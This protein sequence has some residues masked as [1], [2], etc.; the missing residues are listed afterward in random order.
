M[1]AA[2]TISIYCKDTSNAVQVP[3]SML[4]YNITD[5]PPWF[6]SIL[7]GMQHF[8]LLFGG[9]VSLPLLLAP[10]LCISPKDSGVPFLISSIFFVA[11]LDTLL[12]LTLGVRLPIIQGS[13]FTFFGPA[14]A[15][16]QLPRWQCPS[17]SAI[18][19]MNYED[20]QEL[21]FSR[22]REIQGAI[23]LSSLV[24]VLLGFTGAVGFLVRFIGP[25]TVVPTIALTGLSLFGVAAPWA[26]RHWGITIFAI[27][28][29]TFFS[30]Y[31]PRI[32]WRCVSVAWEER[33]RTA[34]QLFPVLMTVVIAWSLCAILTAAGALPDDPKAYGYSARTDIKLDTLSQTPWFRFPYPFQWGWPTFSLSGLSMISGVLAGIV[35]S[36]GDYYACARIAGAPPPPTHA[37]NRGI[38]MEGL[39]CVLAGI[40][41]TGSG[42]TSYSEN[43][44]ALGITKV[45]SRRVV[46][47]AAVVMMGIG[48]FTKFAGLLATMPDP[49]VGGLYCGLF[50]M[51]SAVGLS[52]LQS[53][54]LNSTRNL[55]VLGFSLFMGLTVPH[56]VS[57]HKKTLDTMTSVSQLNQVV[58]V[59]LTTSM[60][61]GG[62][63][64]CLLDN[65]LPGTPQERG[66]TAMHSSVS[67]EDGHLIRE[68]Y[69]P[70][71]FL[72][73]LFNRC[74]CT[75]YLPFWPKPHKEEEPID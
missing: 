10:H 13:T 42:T 38:G 9:T 71:G 47:C 41:G 31:A 61:V 67:T 52:Q 16:L 60:F 48:I 26:G 54:D 21:W 59:L 66:L 15:I 17:E 14:I 8:L 11:G 69:H 7:L 70:P 72:I 35:E 29:L 18:E 62:F 68:I 56:W 36:I 43:I 27:A 75:S 25:L 73:R 20:R 50:G 63:L 30:Q 24:E 58:Q 33:I 44:A 65:I 12:Q 32:R 22:V 34:C 55:F 5:E 64:A 19:S 6:L 1:P 4:L 37:I 3:E 57:E 74:C 46:M 45:G 40:W 49:I 53:V 2:E 39:G 28:L 23:I 51:I